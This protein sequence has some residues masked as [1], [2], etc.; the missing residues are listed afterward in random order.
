M[1]EYQVVVGRKEEI[2]VSDA[3][4]LKTDNSSVCIFQKEL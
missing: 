1:A 2:R 3:L 4:R